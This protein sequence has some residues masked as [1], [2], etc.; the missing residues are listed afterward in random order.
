MDDSYREVRCGLCWTIFYLCRC[1]DRGQ[2]YCQDL[3]RK[4]ARRRSSRAAGGR[5]QASDEGRL[6]HRDRQRAYRARRRAIAPAVTHQGSPRSRPSL[7]V[8]AETDRPAP[9]SGEGVGGGTC[10]GTTDPEAHLHCAVCGQRGYFIR[11]E[12]L[13]WLRGQ[14]LL[15]LRI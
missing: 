11:F 8:P 14:H 15:R 2:R 4:E 6:D 5:H 9:M 1:C 3:C 13:G 10:D 12:T 7:K